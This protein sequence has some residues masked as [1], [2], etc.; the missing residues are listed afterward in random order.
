MRP[1]SDYP[2][3]LQSVFGA[4]RLTFVAV[5]LGLGSLALVRLVGGARRVMGGV[6][7][8][9]GVQTLVFFAGLAKY[10]RDDF[11]NAQVG[12]YLG[13]GAGA[14]LVLAGCVAFALHVRQRGDAPE[15]APAPTL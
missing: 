15:A 6:L 1:F 14:G 3:S 13:F 12:L 4:D 2:E 8:G 7:A 9:A 5:A 11:D 10:V